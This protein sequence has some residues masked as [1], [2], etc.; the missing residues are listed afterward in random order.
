MK[1]RYD[2]YVTSQNTPRFKERRLLFLVA[3]GILVLN[4]ALTAVFLA[5]NMTWF[6]VCA[7]LLAGFTVVQCFDSRREMWT[8]GYVIFWIISAFAASAALFLYHKA[9]WWFIGYGI[10]LVTFNILALLMLKKKFN[11]VQRR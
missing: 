5:E 9:Y 2:C 11:K 10:E 1:K 4:L 3:M 8:W 6:L 7:F